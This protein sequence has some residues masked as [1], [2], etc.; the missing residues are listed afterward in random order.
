MEDLH[1]IKENNKNFNFLKNVLTPSITQAIQHLN[2]RVVIFDI[3]LQGN[4]ML[5]LK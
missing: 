1:I 3:I 4:Q 2:Q 5:R